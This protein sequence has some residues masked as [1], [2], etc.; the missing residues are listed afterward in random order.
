MKKNLLSVL[1]LALLVVNLALTSV[2]MFAVMGS[3]KKTGTLINNIAK[4]LNLELETDKEENEDTT[5]SMENT[6]TNSD[7]KGLTITLKKSEGDDKTHYYMTSVSLWMD[8]TNEDYAKYSEKLPD[9]IQ[10]IS[11]VVSSCVHNHTIEE[12]DNEE[13]VLNEILEK[14]QTMYNSKFIYKVTFYDNMSQ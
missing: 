13:D 2:M 6:E 10:A 14:I 7:I 11:G 3:V 4:I 9:N 8:T 12:M 5:V 1:I